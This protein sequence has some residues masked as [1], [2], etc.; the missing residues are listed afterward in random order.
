VPFLRED[1]NKKQG[2]KTKRKNERG[3]K[4]RA[5]KADGIDKSLICSKLAVV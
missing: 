3:R 4:T 2:K 5:R 1:I